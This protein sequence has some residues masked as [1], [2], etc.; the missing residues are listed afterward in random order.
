ML[1]DSNACPAR[2]SC[3][4]VLHLFLY[5][6]MGTQWQVTMASSCPSDQCIKQSVL[7]SFTLYLLVFSFSFL[8]ILLFLR[9]VGLLTFRLPVYLQ[10][11]PQVTRM[12]PSCQPYFDHA[13]IPPFLKKQRGITWPLA[14]HCAE[15]SLPWTIKCLN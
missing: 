11:D 8:S 15:I 12:S 14:L 5:N 10:N 3:D 13:L 1:A 7:N 4:T 9:T 2:R 6:R